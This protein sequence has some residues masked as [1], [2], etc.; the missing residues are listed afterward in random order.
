MILGR[1]M[2]LSCPRAAL[3]RLD[4]DYRLAGTT[5]SGKD[6]LAAAAFLQNEGTT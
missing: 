5:D 3:R 6:R 2:S 1:F 4:R